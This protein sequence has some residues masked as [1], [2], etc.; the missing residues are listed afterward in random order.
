MKPLLIFMG[1]GMLFGFSAQ[2]SANTKDGKAIFTESC[3]VCHSI[4]PPPKNAP[5]IIPL[6]SHYHL[7]FK[8]KKEGVDHLVAYMKSPNKDKAVD[9]QA[10]TRFGLMPALSLPDSELRTVAEWV[11]DQ[12]NPNMGVRGGGPGSGMGMGR[13]QR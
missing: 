11:W 5:P 10:I 6:A 13:G 2:A 3:S 1:A 8:T 4:S 9:T 7:K 12:Y